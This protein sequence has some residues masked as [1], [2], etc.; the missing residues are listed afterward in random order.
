MIKMKTLLC[1]LTLQCAGTIAVA[2]P[3]ESRTRFWSADDLG[4]ISG[5]LFSEMQEKAART[6][7]LML[8]DWGTHTA[9]ITVRSADGM[10]EQHRDIADFF[11]VLGG[12]AVLVTGGTLVH[13][14]EKSA[15]ELRAVGIKNGVERKLRAGDIV[16]IP[17]GVPHQLLVKTEFRYY[18][19]KAHA[20][21]AGSP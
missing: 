9:A 21:A 16:Y 20:A 18:V 5:R 14:S 12:E 1:W 11:I 4:E 3:A 13:A 15:G 17:P 6:N 7:G 8:G 2:S 10:A 19:I